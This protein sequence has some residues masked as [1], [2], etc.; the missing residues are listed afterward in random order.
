M[1]F[2]VLKFMEIT[3]KGKLFFGV[4]THELLASSQ[5][6]IGENVSNY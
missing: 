2:E 3:I 5:S 4:K 6:T 1:L